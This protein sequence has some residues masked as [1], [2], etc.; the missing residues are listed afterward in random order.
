M[1]SADIIKTTRAAGCI[2]EFKN[3]YK[4]VFLSS[5]K[6]MEVKIRTAGHKRFVRGKRYLN[7]RH[8]I[9]EI[10]R[11]MLV[12]DIEIRAHTDLSGVL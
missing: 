11:Y 9:G 8:K 4:S 6:E 2:D 5:V 12:K 1:N 3:I 7:D 10:S